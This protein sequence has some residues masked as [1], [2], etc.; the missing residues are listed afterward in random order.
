MQHATPRRGLALA[1]AAFA[2]LPGCAHTG[3]H[4]ERAGGMV[5]FHG[6]IDTFEGEPSLGLGLTLDR[7]R[8]G[9]AEE[10]CK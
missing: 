9:E 8:A 1:L 3:E 2:L 4:K 7:F 6:A 5:Y 10:K